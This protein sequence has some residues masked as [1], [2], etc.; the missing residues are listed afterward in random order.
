MRTQRDKPV[1]L[2]DLIKFDDLDVVSIEKYTD[3]KDC[4]LLKDCMGDETDFCRLVHLENNND[5][6]FKRI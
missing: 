6:M 3:C 5:I 4:F 1:K 2:G